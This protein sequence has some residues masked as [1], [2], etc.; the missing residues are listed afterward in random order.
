MRAKKSKEEDFRAR[1]KF[2][3]VAHKTPGGAKAGRLYSAEYSSTT[4]PYF[5]VYCETLPE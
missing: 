3:R 2:P 1:F 4:A 5:Q